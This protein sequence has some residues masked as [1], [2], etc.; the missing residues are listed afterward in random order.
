M[1]NLV[2]VGRWEDCLRK[3]RILAYVWFFL[4]F[5]LFA[6]RPDHTV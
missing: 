6:L 4:F 3:W 2:D 5:V 1:Q